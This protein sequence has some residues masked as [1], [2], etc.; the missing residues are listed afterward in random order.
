MGLWNATQL[1]ETLATKLI[2]VYL[3]DCDEYVS[4]FQDAKFSVG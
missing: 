3:H 4:E 2:R 1:K